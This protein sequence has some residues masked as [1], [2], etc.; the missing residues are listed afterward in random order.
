[1]A[2]SDLGREMVVEMVVVTAPEM[3]LE[4]V[5]S[6]SVVLVAVA[7]GVVQDCFVQT[8]VSIWSV[9]LIWRLGVGMREEEMVVVVI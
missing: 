7:L 5:V 6:V 8:V 9:L 2:L 3:E 4:M 1:M